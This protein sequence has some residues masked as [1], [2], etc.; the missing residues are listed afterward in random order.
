MIS[1]AAE[2]QS[3]LPS[4]RRNISRSVSTKPTTPSYVVHELFFFFHIKCDIDAS[5]MGRSFG[6]RKFLAISFEG[7]FSFFILYIS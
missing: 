7:T 1:E 5:L 4:V 3:A 6:K 2:K